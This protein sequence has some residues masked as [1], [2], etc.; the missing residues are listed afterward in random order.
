[1]RK[2]DSH[3]GKCDGDNFQICSQETENGLQKKSLNL[4]QGVLPE[5]KALGCCGIILLHTV[6]MSLFYLICLRHLL[7]GSVKS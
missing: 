5:T 1:M 3:G 4:I 2:V 6:K 7:I